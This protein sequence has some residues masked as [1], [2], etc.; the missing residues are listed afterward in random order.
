MDAAVRAR[1]AEEER[2]RHI[3][4]DLDPRVGSR[5]RARSSERS[6]AW[7]VVD[8]SRWWGGGY[9]GR[10][11]EVSYFSALVAPT[12]VFLCAIL[13]AFAWA[14]ETLSRT[15]VNRR[16]A[17]TVG[18]YFAAQTLLLGGGWLAG[19]DVVQ[20]HILFVFCWCLTETIIAVWLEPWFAVPAAVV[21]GAGFL[22]AARWP[23]LVHPIMALSNLVFTVVL[24]RVWIPREDVEAIRAQRRALRGRARRWLR[25]EKPVG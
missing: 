18:L 8:V 12:L 25:G 20:M 24:V 15:L 5:T 19:I 7:R 22:L 6:S 21:G 13:V 23:A 2:L 17:L 3:E 11:T 1:A 9:D 14:R 10:G 4:E 16:I